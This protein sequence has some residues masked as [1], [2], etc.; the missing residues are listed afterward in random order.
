MLARTHRLIVI[1]QDG[2]EGRRHNCPVAVQRPQRG[3]D[4]LPAVQPDGVAPQIDV[5]ELGERPRRED[6]CKLL[7]LPI[8]PA[9]ALKAVR[10]DVGQSGLERLLVEPHDRR[11]VCLFAREALLLELVLELGRSEGRRTQLLTR[12][13]QTRR[14]HI[15]AVHLVVG[16]QQPEIEGRLAFLGE[17]GDSALCEAPA[18]SR[19]VCRVG[20]DA[21]R[22]AEA[23]W[24]ALWQCRQLEDGRVRV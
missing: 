19:V 23:R 7:G 2:S 17:A 6:G 12:L 21:R 14:F 4:G 13:P 16:R 18:A 3:Y 10:L 24:V 1:V 8:A 20:S 15:G 22:K 5:G 9:Q 11:Q